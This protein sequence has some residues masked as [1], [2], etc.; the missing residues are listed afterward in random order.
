MLLQSPP[1]PAVSP[2]DPAA[3]ATRLPGLKIPVSLVRFRVQALSSRPTSEALGT[4][5]SP[6][7]Q[8]FLGCH[9]WASAGGSRVHQVHR[10]QPIPRRLIRCCY[11]AISHRTSR[12]PAPFLDSA[13]D[14]GA[15]LTRL[16]NAN[17]EL[18]AG[19]QA[20]HSLRELALRGDCSISS[21]FQQL[22]TLGADL[23]QYA[24][25]VVTKRKRE[26]RGR[27]VAASC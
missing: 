8:R 16:A 17:R 26:A 22:H 19:R 12:D 5:K 10:I 1:S 11:L 15:W 27:P 18:L 9:W 25:I 24:D 3:L 20:G 6:G 13:I 7:P 23:A 2:A 4:A 21:V 14:L